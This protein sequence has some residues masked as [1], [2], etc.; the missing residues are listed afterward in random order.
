[1]AED[2]SPTISRVAVEIDYNVDFKLAYQLRDL[3]IVHR[4]HIDKTIKCGDDPLS[5]LASII[6]TKRNRS[7]IK[8]RPI[9]MFKAAGDCVRDRMVAKIG[10]A[11]GNTDFVVGIPLAAPQS[12]L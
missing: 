8:A 1:M 12:R 5:H 7:R 4:F 9:V 3:A 6:C 10:C 11:I 2:A